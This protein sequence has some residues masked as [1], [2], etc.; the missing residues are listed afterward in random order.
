MKGFMLV[1]ELAWDVWNGQYNAFADEADYMD[2][3]E[4]E[5]DDKCL[6]RLYNVTVRG[7]REYWAL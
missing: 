3:G 7:R 5:Q 6:L 2:Y 4:E 1:K